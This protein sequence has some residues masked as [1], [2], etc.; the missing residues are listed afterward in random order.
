M[1]VRLL[2]LSCLS[3]R[4]LSCSQDGMFTVLV[5]YWFWMKVTVL[6]MVLLFHLLSLSYHCYILNSRI[7]S[8]INKTLVTVFLFG[9]DQTWPVM[10]NSVAMTTLYEYHEVTAFLTMVQNSTF[11]LTVCLWRESR[12]CIILLLC[13][14]L[15]SRRH[16]AAWTKRIIYHLMVVWRSQTHWLSA[17]VSLL[18]L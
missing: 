9:S 18:N 4:I 5:L 16:K 8:S 3:Q 12:S 7:H 13:L 1:S 2:E 17:A 14:Q 10:K 6:L 11:E 15:I